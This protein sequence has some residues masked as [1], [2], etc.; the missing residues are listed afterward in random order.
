MVAREIADGESGEAAE[1]ETNG[2]VNAVFSSSLAGSQN[3]TGLRVGGGVAE[4]AG[5]A[6]AD[7][8]SDVFLAKLKKLIFRVRRLVFFK[9]DA[10]CG[11]TFARK[12]RSRER[13]ARLA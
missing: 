13:V 4:G 8:I 1:R 12:D 10:V 3:V 2:K 11:A 5:E 9:D 6:K 7:G